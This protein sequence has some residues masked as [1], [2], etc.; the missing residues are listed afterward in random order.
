VD[1][2][3]LSD[4]RY[5]LRRF[6]RIREVAARAAQI[7]PQQY[8]LLLHVK[9]IEGREPATIRALA[10]RLQIQHHGVVQLIDRPAA[11][12]MVQRQRGE[13]DRRHVVVGLLPRGQAVL[14]R[15]AAH[16]V[17][18]L[19]TDGPALVSSLER[20]LTKSMR[21]RTSPRRGRREDWR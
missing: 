13:A 20:L 5:H 19:E 1:Y 2:Q 4:F 12:R 8:L 7:E 17:A 14:A 16:S 9:G 11:R 3:A 18:E 21:F 15:L 6:L 10:D